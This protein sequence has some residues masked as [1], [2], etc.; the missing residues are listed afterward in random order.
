MNFSWKNSGSATFAESKI[1]APLPSGIA[2]VAVMTGFLVFFVWVGMLDVTASETAAGL[3]GARLRWL[4]SLMP[5][6]VSAGTF[7]AW[8]RTQAPVYE[9]AT[10]VLIDIMSIAFMSCMGL[11]VATA[12][13]VSQSMGRREPGE[14]ERFGWTAAKIA[15]LFTGLYG[16]SAA[17]FPD[18]FMGLFSHDQEVIEVGRWPLRM[19]GAGTWMIGIGMVLA[20]ALFGAGNTRFV[21]KV[22][23][24]LHFVCLIPLSYFFGIVLGWKL[25]GIWLAGLLYILFLAL[26]MTLKF[27]S[28]TWKN[29][30]I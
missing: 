21:M 29:I 4:H 14:A 18:T 30:Q 10:K 28:G 3:D 17:A 2:T 22:E 24:T 25:V 19:L 15:A 8:L 5:V 27:R 11:G 26:T 20:Q 13:L 7:D 1:K 23:I 16:L 6:P 12:T 9:A